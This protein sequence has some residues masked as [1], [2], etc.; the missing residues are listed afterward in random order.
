MNLINKAEQKTLKTKEHILCNP[1]YIKF[2][3]AKGPLVLK[4]RVMNLKR[5]KIT[6]RKRNTRWVFLGCLEHYIS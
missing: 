2:K 3:K 5:S 1:I 6:D 4:V